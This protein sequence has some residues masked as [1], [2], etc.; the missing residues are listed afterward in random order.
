MQINGRNA[1]TWEAKFRLD[2][3]IVGMT[4]L[5]VLRRERISQEG[6]ATMPEFNPQISQNNAD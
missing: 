5:K 6:E 4:V 2:L 1:L 3:K